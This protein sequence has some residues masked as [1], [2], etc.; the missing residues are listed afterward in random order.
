MALSKMW[1]FARQNTVLVSASS[2][3]QKGNR[4][5]PETVEHH[6]ADKAQATKPTVVSREVEHLY[7]NR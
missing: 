3:S 1:R 7:A 4:I 6:P 2:C 5:E